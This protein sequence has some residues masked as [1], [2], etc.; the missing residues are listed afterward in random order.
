MVSE[1]PA[2]GQRVP[3]DALLGLEWVAASDRHE[4]DAYLLSRLSQAWLVEGGSVEKDHAAVS[5]VCCRADQLGVGG[6]GAVPP[7]EFKR[8]TRLDGQARR[9]DRVVEE[10]H[11][12]APA[13]I[14]NPIDT[15]P[16]MGTLFNSG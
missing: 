2:Q 16:S 1:L 14:C 5:A 11:Y 3:Q 7:V 10:L 6:V 12:L 15:V 4:R 9:K 13:R 8:P